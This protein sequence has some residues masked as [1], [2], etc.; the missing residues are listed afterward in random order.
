MAHVQQ[1]RT[2]TL[3]T[4]WH[5]FVAKD[6]MDI[7]KDTMTKIQQGGHEQ[8][9][10]YRAIL[11]DIFTGFQ[12]NETWLLHPKF[13]E[14]FLMWFTVSNCRWCYPLQCCYPVLNGQPKAALRH[15]CFLMQHFFES[16]IRSLDPGMIFDDDWLVHGYLLHFR[17]RCA[18]Q[19]LFNFNFKVMKRY[20][21]M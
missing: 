9:D 6:A 4:R 17:T 1:M 14:T 11:P 13:T 8:R 19:A 15:L 21:S 12:V 20:L 18:T 16:L 5:S 7:H 2:A 3:L 10:L